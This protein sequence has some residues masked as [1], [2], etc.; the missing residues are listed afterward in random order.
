M[1]P[2]TC[3]SRSFFNFILLFVLTVQI[4]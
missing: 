3:K 4:S 1:V 2:G